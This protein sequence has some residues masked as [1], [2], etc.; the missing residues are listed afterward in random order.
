MRLATTAATSVT[1]LRLVPNLSYLRHSLSLTRTH[2]RLEPA[3]ASDQ[4]DA[5]RPQASSLASPSARMFPSRTPS[6][7]NELAGL[8]MPK[9]RVP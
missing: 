7:E 1:S 5:R 9:H 6:R 8:T 2:R 4:T 3:T